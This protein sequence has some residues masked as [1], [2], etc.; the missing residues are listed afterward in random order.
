MTN[1]GTSHVPSL[2]LGNAGATVRSSVTW[3]GG[4]AARGFSSKA[5]PHWSRLFLRWLLVLGALLMVTAGLL[6]LSYVGREGGARL[7][8]LVSIFSTVDDM[9]FR[10]LRKKRKQQTTMANHAVDSCI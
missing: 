7:I 5:H 8:A 9:V 3:H 10:V 1:N 4:R 6:R 2:G